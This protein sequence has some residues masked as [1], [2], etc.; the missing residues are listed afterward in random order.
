MKRPPGSWIYNPPRRYGF[1][2]KRLL[3]DEYTSLVASITNIYEVTKGEG[4]FKKAV[5][6]PPHHTTNKKRYNIFHH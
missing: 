5:S 3:Y 6:L 2:K 4:I 1:M